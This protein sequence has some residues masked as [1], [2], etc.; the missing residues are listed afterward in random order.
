M[1]RGLV[2]FAA[3]LLFACGLVLS[4]MTVPARVRGFL[5]VAGAWD[6]TLLF[7]MT[8]AL[9]VYFPI[10]RLTRGRTAPIGGQQIPIRLDD[11]LDRRLFGGATLFGVGWGLT[12]ICPG[13]A[14]TLLGQAG[15]PILVLV[16]A[17]IL[18]MF[19]PRIVSRRSRGEA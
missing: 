2:A 1:K 4:Q 16:G 9:A 6:P 10:W 17:M 8:G 13:P 12:G 19:L 7:V 14:I 18:G 3:G 5:D 11:S 15:L